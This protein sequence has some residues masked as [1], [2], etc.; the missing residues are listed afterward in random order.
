M[1]WVEGFVAQ[2]CS[3]SFVAAMLFPIVALAWF[4]NSPMSVGPT[5]YTEPSEEIWVKRILCRRKGLGVV[6]NAT[7]PS[8]RSHFTRM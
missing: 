2:L 6:Y 4:I 5:Q 1:H 3:N 8:L 7:V